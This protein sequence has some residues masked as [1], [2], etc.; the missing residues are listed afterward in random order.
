MWLRVLITFGPQDLSRTLDRIEDINVGHGNAQ[1]D[2]TNIGK[3]HLSIFVT[4]ASIFKQIV[5]LAGW[6]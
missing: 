2:H 1:N 5:W 4:F 6:T 3:V